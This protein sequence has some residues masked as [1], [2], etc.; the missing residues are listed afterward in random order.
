MHQ[1]MFPLLIMNIL[2]NHATR[3]RPLTITE[4]TDFVNREFAAFAFDKDRVMNRSTVTR[5][6]DAMELWTD[7]NLFNFRVVQCGTGGK[8]LFCLER[9][10]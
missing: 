7:G 4:I 3:E 6:L 9:P 2:E 1:T 10:A 5:I 8:K